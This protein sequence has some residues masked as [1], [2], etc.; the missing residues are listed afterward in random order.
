MKIKKIF[1]T[2][3]K[4]FVNRLEVP[5]PE[6]ISAIV[7]PNGCG[8]SNVVDAIRWAMG[9][10]SAKQLRGRQMEDII[11]NGAETQ[12]PLGMAEVSLIFENGDGSFPPEFAHNSEISVTRRLYRSG[13]SEYLINNVAC[14]LKDIQEIFMDTGLGNRAYSI[15]GQGRISTIIEQKPEETRAMLEEA[16]GITKYRRKVEESRRK[17]ELT[18]GN[19]QRV[20]DILIEV[21]RQMRLLK[22]Q[23]GKAK[24]FKRITREIEGLELLL[25]ANSFHALKE[26]SG[27]RMKSTEDFVQEEIALT[28]KLSGIQAEIETMNLELDE[29]DQEITR[30]R[31]VYSNLKEK[32]N[33]KESIIESMVSEKRMQTELENRLKKEQEDLGRRLGELEQERHSLEEKIKEA[34]QAAANLEEEMAILNRRVKGRHEALK[35]AREEFEE[36]RTRLNSGKSKEMSLTQ[37]SGYLNQRIGEITD[38]R[39]RLERER[40]EVVGKIEEINGASRRKNEIREALSRKFARIEEDRIRKRGEL[41]DLLQTKSGAENELKSIEADLN[42]GES[43]LTSL[44]SMTENFEGYKIGV[45]TIM[46]AKDLNARRS[47]HIRGLVADIVQVEPQYEQAVEAVLGDKL[48]YIIVERQEDGK[49]AVDYLKLRAKGRSSFVPLKDLNGHH[50]KGHQNG[51]PLLRDLV[52]VPESYKR[53]M[54]LLLG[55]AALVKDLGEAISEWSGNGK[56]QCLVT[57]DGDVVDSSG[58]ISG[59]KAAHSSHGI[60]ARKREIGEL[61]KRVNR[62]KREREE[63]VAR[64]EKTSLEMEKRASALDDLEEEKFACQE[65]INDLDKTIFRL[66]HEMDQLD[67]L[68]AKIS[69]DLEEKEREKG[70]HREA[71]NRI[72]SELELCKERRKQVEEY[73]AEKEFE[74]KES[75]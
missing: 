41:D 61:K 47:G 59:G 45:R 39:T 36:A 60:L 66:S 27:D 53:L 7:G 75:E 16:A 37:E 29:R 23:A 74:L 10:Q 71:L 50:D 8:K 35:Q 65:K 42:V 20:E 43:R 55:N 44:R 69:Q 22:R 56:D 70:R 33:R 48:Q 54:D 1:M 18:K 32:V 62:L 19:L 12:K 58:I 28:T 64:L 26:E 46:K 57:L 2:G 14:R 13:E 31:D 52:A 17:I 49:E 40:E 5:F 51:F 4:S 72:E 38:S 67:R 25:N 15:I 30:L 21:G 9:E 24:R 11:F 34:G 73:V 68:S 63:C 3:F 6:G